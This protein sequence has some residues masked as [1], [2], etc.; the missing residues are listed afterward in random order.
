MECLVKEVCEG[1]RS[2]RYITFTSGRAMGQNELKSCYEQLLSRLDATQ[3]KVVWE[4][5]FGSLPCRGWVERCRAESLPEKY[6]KHPF[7]YLEGAPVEGFGLAGL[8]LYVIGGEEVGY[9]TRDGRTLGAEYC[10]D[11]GRRLYLS[12]SAGAQTGAVPGEFSGQFASASR[13]MQDAL[14]QAGFGWR[15]VVRTWFYLGHIQRDYPRFNTLR[16]DLFDE[17]G[18]DYSADSNELPASTCIEGA[19]P[20]ADCAMELLCCDKRA[21]T[22]RRIY[23]PGQNEA[24]GS[25]YLHRP[26]FS[27]AMLL[28]T[29]RFCEL[30]LSGTAS[31]DVQ[32]RSVH[33]SDPARQIAW[34][35]QNIRN[36]LHAAGMDFSD[37][38]QSTCFFKH[39]QDVRYFEPACEALGIAPFPHIKVRGNVCRE[40]LLFEIDG[41]A[42]K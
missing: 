18:V 14:E 16:R 39:S 33:L 26:T 2:Q 29:D 11:G 4:K 35:L 23:N 37:I 8:T 20:H 27:R 9:L 42:L 28:R 31:I 25:E 40:D 13:Q 10:L 17:A 36:L 3:G 15:D 12:S 6:K 19:V 22:L 34:S 41:I 1:G 32:G 30:Q 24:E 5:A 21:V 7:T 38:A